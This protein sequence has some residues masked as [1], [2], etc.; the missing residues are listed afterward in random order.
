MRERFIV[1]SSDQD[2]LAPGVYK[3]PT[4]ER[5]RKSQSNMQWENGSVVLWKN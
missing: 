1:S 4:T 5:H 3:V 2:A